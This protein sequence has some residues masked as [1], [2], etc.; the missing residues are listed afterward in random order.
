MSTGSHETPP[1]LPIPFAVDCS[2]AG[3]GPLV[4]TVSGDV[5]IASAQLLLDVVI[6][7]TEA[8]PSSGV[9]LDFTGVDFMDSTGLRALL[10][11][12]RRLEDEAAG[13]VLMK[14]ADSVRKLLSLAGLDDRI[15]IAV[16]LEQAETLLASRGGRI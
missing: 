3:A 8:A 15:P 4:A 9:V 6:A 10:E 16:D 5:D 13:L 12:V 14:P 7:G 2:R 11:I 1:G